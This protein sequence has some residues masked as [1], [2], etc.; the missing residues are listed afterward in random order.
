MP[1]TTAQLDQE[2]DKATT[3]TPDEVAKLPQTAQVFDKPNLVFDD[4]KW[5]QEGAHIT[6]VCSPSR[7]DCLHV[8]I[9][10][11]EGKTLELVAGKYRFVSEEESRQL[12]TRS[13]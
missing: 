10:V 9:P 2:L 13:K 4:H 5:Q 1:E 8:G 7:V 11:P 6:D 12:R 3:Y